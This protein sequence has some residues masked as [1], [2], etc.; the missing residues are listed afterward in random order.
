MKLNAKK[1]YYIIFSWS[2]QDFAARL[3][4]NGTKLDRVELSKLLGVW[5]SDNLSWSRNYSEFCT[6]AYSRHSM[7]T[8]LKYVGTKIEDLIQVYVMFIRSVTEYCS[9]VYH[10]RRTK[11]EIN[12]FERIQKTCLKV[13]LGEMYVDYYSAL[14]M[15]GLD[16]LQNRRLKRCLDFSLRSI[17]H[18]R[19][20]KMFPF[21]VANP[22]YIIR[23]NEKFKV[24]FAQTCLAQV[25]TRFRFRLVIHW[26]YIGYTFRL[27]SGLK[28]WIDNGYIFSFKFSF[29]FNSTFRFTF[30]FISSFIVSFTFSF[31]FSFI[32]SFI[33]S[34]TFSFFFNNTFSNI[35]LFC[36]AVSNSVYI[37][38]LSLKCSFIFHTYFHIQFWNQLHFW[39]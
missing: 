23:N 16:S 5:I 24:N 13:I 34:F 2:V 25:S 22:S 27:D 28:Y 14:E 9:V 15:T 10:S 36:N 11:E 17:K 29:I 31:T 32:F 8:R 38:I 21:N 20:M 12:V 26:L 35:Y 37:N 3:T 39:F 1:S 6:Q 18:P 4:I 30:S 19:N 33:F 7:L